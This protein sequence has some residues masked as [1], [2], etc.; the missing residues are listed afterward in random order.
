MEYVS[1]I[2][3]ILQLVTLALAVVGFFVNRSKEHD[4]QV[5]AQQN[6]INQQKAT[7]E[8]LQAIKDT[9]KDYG[10][11]ISAVELIVQ[12]MASQHKANHNQDIGGVL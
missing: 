8:T 3:S 9:L 5:I 11:R 4:A 7:T 10:T 1:T 2:A 12:L 6:A